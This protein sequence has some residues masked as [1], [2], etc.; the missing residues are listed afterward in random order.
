M[1]ED[2]WFLALILLAPLAFLWA[3]T[4]RASLMYSSVALMDDSPSTWRTRFSF[5]PPLCIATAVVLLAIALSRP[6]TPDAETRVNR[7]GIAIMMVVDR[8]GSM[9]ARDLV[10]DDLSVDRLQV[11]QKVLRQFVLG[12]ES[13]AAG[14]PDDLIGLIS[15]AGYADSQCPLTINHHSL[16]AMVDQLEIA[17]RRSEDGT[18]IGDALALAV[19]RIRRSKA[20]SKIVI[21]LTDGVNNAG[22]IPPERA[23]ELAQQFGIKVYCIGA[24]TEGYAPVPVP[25]MFGDVRLR[26][27]PVRIDEETLRTIAQKTGGQYYRA[28]DSETLSKIYETIDRLERTE[29]VETRYLQYDEHFAGFVFPGLL[30]IVVALVTSKTLF[31][32]L[33]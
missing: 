19:E 30:L 18:A 9:I 11:V 32:S 28:T 5:V 17:R 13:G 10:Q 24:G 31:S 8:S 2:R 4:R 7:E 21:L 26:H 1:P 3:R 27:V 20:E 25:T 16:V 12:N 33:P 6:R 22:I 23:A 29:I 14:R 15:F